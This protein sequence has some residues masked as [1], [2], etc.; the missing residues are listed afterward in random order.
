MT[1]LY[2]VLELS[3]SCSQE[4]IKKHYNK[5]VLKYHPDKKTGDKDMYELI[6]TAYSILSNPEK[7]ENYDKERKLIAST[8]DLS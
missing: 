3:P 2:D 4:E 8:V 7:R 1:D 5:M 6:N